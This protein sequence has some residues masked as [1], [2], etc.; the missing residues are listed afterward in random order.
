MKKG[1]GLS[2]NVV[3]IAAVAVIV[4][5]VLVAIFT[6]QMGGFTEGLEGTTEC[7][8]IG[9]TQCY[10]EE[11]LPENHTIIGRGSGAGCEDEDQPIC[12]RD[13]G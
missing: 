11:S 13:D 12:A 5:V 3:V 6:G 4:L 2:M 7:E 9:G 1:Q 10:D 8:S